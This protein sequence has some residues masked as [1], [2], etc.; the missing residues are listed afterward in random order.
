MVHRTRTSGHRHKLMYRKITMVD[1]NLV[2]NQVHKV[3]DLEFRL[4]GVAAL[5][6]MGDTQV[7]A[8]VV[9]MQ[10]DLFGIENLYIYN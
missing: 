4:G 5:L 2:S 10:T 7:L 3:S 8:T 6:T 9:P 1:C